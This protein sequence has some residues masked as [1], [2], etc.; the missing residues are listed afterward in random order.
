TWGSN[1][2]SLKLESRFDAGVLARLE[3]AGH[4]VERVAPFTSMMGHAGVVVRHA[5]GLFEG[6]ADPR[7]DGCVA[8]F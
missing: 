2:H 4:E 7:S 5:N 6:A 3:Q 1:S 8:A